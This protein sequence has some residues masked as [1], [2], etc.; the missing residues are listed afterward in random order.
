[1]YEK[2][3]GIVLR[4][5]KYSDKNSI[6]HVLTDRHGRMAFLVPQGASRTARLR[7]ALFQPLSIISFEARITPGRDIY[8]FK[9]A[10]SLYQLPQLYAD[11]VKNA[12]AM[13][14]SELLS[15]SIQESEEN[16]TLFQYIV[17]AIRLLDTM[18]EGVANF[19]IC[20]LYGLGVFLGIQPDTGS[21]HNGYWFDMENGTFTPS[22]PMSL[23]RLNPDEAKVIV[24]LSRMNFSNIARFHFNR[25]QRNEILD[26][27]LNYYRLHNSTLGTLKSP[28]ILKALFD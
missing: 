27:A 7:S 18:S 16:D 23:H 25:T 3:A 28:D 11:P 6:A 1:M 19:H 14:M 20:F 17:T 10:Q 12:I 4:T 22:R 8:T 24:L 26:T 9:D 2:L 15:R 13:F 21:Y 5:I